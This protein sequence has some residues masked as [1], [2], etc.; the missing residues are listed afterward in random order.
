MVS[1]L[2]IDNTILEQIAENLTIDYF[3]APIDERYFEDFESDD[4]DE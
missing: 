4:G 1:H 3:V 2:L